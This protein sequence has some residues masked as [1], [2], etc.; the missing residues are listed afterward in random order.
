MYE[1]KKLGLLE[2]LLESVSPASAVMINLEISL[3]HQ[4]YMEESATLSRTLLPYINKVTDYSF[5]GP[6]SHFIAGRFLAS[7]VTHVKDT[8]SVVECGLVLFALHLN[9]RA[10]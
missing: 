2:A 5:L 10:L 8:H 7:L 1:Q 6:E 9:P 3:V 4:G